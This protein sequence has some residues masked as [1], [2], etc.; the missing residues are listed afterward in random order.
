MPVS[1][2]SPIHRILVQV[3]RVFL[4]LRVQK[5]KYKR[6]YK[7]ALISCQK[8]GP[9]GPKPRSHLGVVNQHQVCTLVI[10]ATRPTRGGCPTLLTPTTTVHLVTHSSTRGV[11]RVTRSAYHTAS[12][13]WTS[14]SSAARPDS[15]KPVLK[16]SLPRR[17]AHDLRP[18][19]PVLR[20]LPARPE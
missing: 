7:S 17:C 2:G 19:S 11:Q 3:V 10:T 1:G 14:T 16:N 20:D 12:D 9:P 8:A 13:P 4:L 15:V 5:K 18:L 6:K